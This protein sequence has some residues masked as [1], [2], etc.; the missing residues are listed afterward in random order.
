MGK[1]VLGVILSYVVR[2]SAVCCFGGI[3]LVH[4]GVISNDHW[5]WHSPTLNAPIILIVPL[6]LTRDCLDFLPFRLLPV[7]RHVVQVR[8]IGFEFVQSDYWRA[9]RRTGQLIEQ[10]NSKM[11]NMNTTNSNACSD[12]ED[13]NRK[14]HLPNGE[15]RKRER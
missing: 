6:T 7:Q 9:F 8:H 1:T 10:K 14:P 2:F 4:H 11:Q 13:D 3:L 12:G 5:C 15:K